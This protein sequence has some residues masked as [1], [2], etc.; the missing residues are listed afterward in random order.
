MRCQPSTCR[1]KS[2][3]FNLNASA[4][5]IYFSDDSSTP[6]A[7]HTFIVDC[8]VYLTIYLSSMCVCIHSTEFDMLIFAE[9]HMRRM[10]IEHVLAFTTCIHSRIKCSQMGPDIN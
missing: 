5:S 8:K 1:N 7:I 4:L 3:Y 2:S 10:H 9:K 6:Y